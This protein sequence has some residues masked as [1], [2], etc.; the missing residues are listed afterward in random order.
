MSKKTT[1]Q[2]APVQDTEVVT[3]PVTDDASDDQST[4]DN[5]VTDTETTETPPIDTPPVTDDASDDNSE[6]D[7]KEVEQKAP[8]GSVSVILERGTYLE[9]KFYPAWKYKMT[10]LQAEKVRIFYS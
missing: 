10:P 7:Q 6:E 4:V 8:K 1:K 2:V 9:G 5:I 3:P